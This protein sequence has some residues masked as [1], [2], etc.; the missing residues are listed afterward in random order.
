MLVASFQDM[1]R[2]LQADLPP[3]GSKSSRLVNVETNLE[4]GKCSRGF[5]DRRPR[6]ELPLLGRSPRA[7]VSRWVNMECNLEPGKYP[8]GFGARS[9]PCWVEVLEPLRLP[10][11][12]RG[13]K[14]GTRQVSP[15]L[16]RPEAPPGA[17]LLGRSPRAVAAPVGS[18]WKQIWNPANVPV[19]FAPGGPTRSFP[20]WVEFLE[21]LRLPLGQRGSK[22]G[23]RQ[24]SPWLWRPEAPPG[25]SPVGSKSSSRCGSRWVN[26]EANLE[27]GKCPRGFGAQRPHPELPCWVEVL[28]PL[29]LPLGQRGSKFG[30]RQMSPWL[31]RPEAPP[32][33]SPVGSKS[34][35]RCVSRWV[36][37][38]ANLEPIKCP[39]WLWCPEVL[40]GGPPNGKATIQWEN[41][42]C[43][44]Y[45]G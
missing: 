13:S 44:I 42:K 23:T 30:T 5:G 32:G 35:S 17:S 12:Q 20:C 40:A 19:A 45:C 39:R 18:T 38:E 33:A 29:R 41:E 22:F 7:S 21:P 3:V 36:N 10:L 9:F 37:V 26:V 8:R 34:S 43:Y 28:E 16:W 4:P 31:S 2:V 14:F 24:V 15:W 27:P 6:P 1:D 11:G 25:A